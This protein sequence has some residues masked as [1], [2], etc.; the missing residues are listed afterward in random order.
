MS[1]RQEPMSIN[2]DKVR[3]V[4][5]KIKTAETPKDLVDTLNA[6][7]L[8]RFDGSVTG[9]MSP[10][11]KREATEVA[12][13]VYQDHNV[14]IVEDPLDEVCKVVRYD[15]SDW[16]DGGWYVGEI[17]DVDRIFSVY[18]SYAA[19]T[20][21]PDAAVAIHI[22]DYRGRVDRFLYDVY[23]SAVDVAEHMD[24]Y[25]TCAIMENCLRWSRFSIHDLGDTNMS[26]LGKIT[27][28]D[29][30]GNLYQVGEND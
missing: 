25:A 29:K 21:Y 24:M 15:D 7:V 18:Y 20:S 30:D 2:L 11:V 4:S 3:E 26:H 8:K 28:S 27:V 13:I 23:R 19:L 6:A 22:R 14:F 12:R 5:E 17:V 16:C 10:I 9:F 1:E